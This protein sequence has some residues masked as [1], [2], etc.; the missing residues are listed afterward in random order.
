MDDTVQPCRPAGALDQ[1]AGIKPFGKDPPPAKGA[2]HTKR[3][4]RR[5]RRTLRPEHG[6]S[7]TCRT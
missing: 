3:R 4:V 2:E 7:D 6:R 1:H 5:R